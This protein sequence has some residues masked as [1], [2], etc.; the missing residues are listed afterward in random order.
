MRSCPQVLVASAGIT[1]ER[2]GVTWG[3]RKRGAA[4]P[5][6]NFKTLPT[7][8]LYTG[9][10]TALDVGTV[11]EDGRESGRILARQPSDGVEVLLGRCS[12]SMLLKNSQRTVLLVIKSCGAWRMTSRIVRWKQ[13]KVLLEVKGGQT[14]GTTCDDFAGSA[15]YLQ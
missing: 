4:E 9:T 7:E 3:C 1:R 11:Q 14:Q 5:A 8:I 15:E 10:G 13:A 12:A 6:V 2:S